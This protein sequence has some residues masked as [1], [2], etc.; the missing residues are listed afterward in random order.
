DAVPSAPAA[1]ETESIVMPEDMR[2]KIAEMAFKK[3]PGAMDIWRLRS[4]Q[5]QAKLAAYDGDKCSC[6]ACTS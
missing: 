2:S 3:V 4:K 6:E 5:E 1:M